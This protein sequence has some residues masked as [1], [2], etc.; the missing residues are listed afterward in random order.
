MKK[1]LFSLLLALTVL[2]GVPFPVHGE[3]AG[4]PEVSAKAAVVMDALTGRVIFGKNPA[5][6]LP[7][8][9]TTKIMTALLTLEQP[10]LDVM[11][12][13]DEGAIQVEG[14]SMGLRVGDMVSL[15]TLAAGM[16]L[17]SGNDAANAAAVR[18]AGSISEFV[19]MMN[20]RAAQLGLSDTNFETPSGL[21][22][23]NHYTTAKDL[24]LLARA[25]LQNQYFRD[26]SSQSTM[27]VSFGNPP[28]DRWLTN[29]NRLLKEYEGCIGV[30][31]GFTKKA[32]RCLVSAAERD[33]LTLICVTLN[34]PDD[35]ADHK[36]LLDAAFAALSPAKEPEIPKN[37]PVAG[38]TAETVALKPGGEETLFLTEEEASRLKTEILLPKF[39]YAP[40]TA[41]QEAGEIR[42]LLDGETIYTRPLLAAEN[43]DVLEKEPGFWERLLCWWK[44]LFDGKDEKSD[45]SR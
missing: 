2:L 39:L 45:I 27:K 13:A 21:D 43:V 15:R 29:H 28:A 41:G 30:K 32:G 35:W 20:R 14:S 36:A 37:V 8:A 22:G 18:I 7:M 16:L 25:A 42:Y 4:M 3:G 17:P 1:R 10:G 23:Q 6:R 38:G 12:E 44:G 19:M 5:E 33:G 24:A 34:A 11:F 26:I 31:T 9:S 40:V